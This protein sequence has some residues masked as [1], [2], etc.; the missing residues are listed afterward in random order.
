MLTQD[1]NQCKINLLTKRGLLAFFL[2]TVMSVAFFTNFIYL[3]NFTFFKNSLLL[4]YL[5]FIFTIFAYFWYFSITKPR[6]EQFKPQIQLLYLISTLIIGALLVFVLP[7]KIPLTPKSQN[8]EIIATREQN[9]A[10]M[11]NEVWLASISLPDNS[12]VDVLDANQ[13]GNWETVD[14]IHVSR[15]TEIASLSWQEIPASNVQLRFVS[16]PWSGIVRVVW[17]NNIY[18]IDLYSDQSTEKTITLSQKTQEILTTEEILQRSGLF[19]IYALSLGFLFLGTSLWFITRSIDISSY[20]GNHRWK[21]LWYATPCVLIWIVYLLAL[22]PGVMISDSIDQWEQMIGIRQ[23][24]NFH[25]AFNTLT[26]W[27]ITRLWLSPA[28]VALAQIL[29]LSAIFGLTMSELE[30]WEVPLW[31]PAILTIFFSLSIVNGLMV[32]NLWKDT[33]Y[34][35]A[36]LGVFAVL[37]RLVRT[38][39]HWLINPINMLILFIALTF[40]SLYRHN[41]SAVTVALIIALLCFWNKIYRIRILSVALLWAISYFLITGPIYQILNISPF[42]PSY[43][44]TLAHQISAYV[45]NTDSPVIEESQ[46]I[47]TKSQSLT[48]WEDN[49]NCYTILPLAFNNE[50]DFMTL[51]SSEEEFL[52]IWSNLILEQPSIV[53]NHQICVSS[54]IWRI[55]QPNDGYIATYAL[56]ISENNIDIEE[57]SKIPFLRN[58]IQNFA[59]VSTQDHLVWFIWRPAFYLYLSIFCI[60]VLAMRFRDISILLLL[61]PPLM[62]SLI[63]LA[64]TPSQNFRYQYGIY[65]IGL[66]SICLLFVRSRRF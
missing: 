58:Q 56:G 4:T 22:W 50:V 32:V 54:I 44:L 15:N 60:A 6:L 33:P 19:V 42:K 7:L 16:H 47:L 62:N 2:G 30:L 20:T 61:V 24:N 40:L 25:P 13:T 46:H 64:V 55:S 17:D 41:G 14:N 57:D 8:L 5:I 12:L 48:S 51:N 28:T 66:V 59:K 34:A 45:H 37:L 11:G 63:L 36:M 53:I 29:V 52:A 35:I 39:G 23:M 27:T 43:S 1:T 21:W 18:E 49:Y 26:N 10:S 38:R 31:C 9:P 3:E 65:L